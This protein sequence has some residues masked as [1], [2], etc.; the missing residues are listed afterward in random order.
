MLI[1]LVLVL[2]VDSLIGGGEQENWERWGEGGLWHHQT[3]GIELY[4][5]PG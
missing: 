3:A 2:T 1:F 5:D 4:R